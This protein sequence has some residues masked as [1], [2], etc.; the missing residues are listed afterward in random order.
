MDRSF[1]DCCVVL[2][3]FGKVIGEFRR[4]N[5]SLEEFC[6][7][8]EWVRFSSFVV[9]YYWLEVVLGKFC[10]GI[11][12]MMDF[13]GSWNFGVVMFCSW[14]FMRCIFIVIILQ[15]FFCFDVII[16]FKIERIKS[17]FCFFGERLLVIINIYMFGFSVQF[18]LCFGLFYREI[19]FLLYCFYQE[20]KL[21]FVV[22]LLMLIL[23]YLLV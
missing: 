2:G 17:W 6:V 18:C 1:L 22:I 12:V 5:Q 8:Q 4:K 11:N 14:R 13:R 10:F 9:F 3:R 23:M 20:R 15:F 7:F 16:S 21:L 19:F